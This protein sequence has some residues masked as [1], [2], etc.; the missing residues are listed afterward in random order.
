MPFLVCFDVFSLFWCGRRPHASR[1]FKCGRRG[2]ACWRTSI[3][4][5]TGQQTIGFCTSHKFPGSPTPNLHTP[6]Q[7]QSYM[8][9]NIGN[10]E[11]EFRPRDRSN[12]THMCACFAFMRARGV[13]RHLAH[14]GTTLHGPTRCQFFCTG[15]THRNSTKPNWNTTTLNAHPN[16]A[17]MSVAVFGWNLS[18]PSK[19]LPP[20]TN[21]YEL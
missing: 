10:W 17:C 4:I 12:V 13:A 21:S 7:S 14:Q 8:N 20:I 5:C 9:H 6:K 3:S 2:P 16:S 18:P 19:L 11:I 1:I 15:H